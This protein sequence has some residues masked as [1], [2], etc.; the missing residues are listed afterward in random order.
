MELS[1]GKRGTGQGRVVAIAP[2]GGDVSAPLTA[3]NNQFYTANAAYGQGAKLGAGYAVYNGT[4]HS[5]IVTGLQPNTYYYVTNAEYNTD[6]VSI[7][8]NIRG[9]S[10]S[11]ATRAAPTAPLP[12]EL[13]TFT[14]TTD[15]NSYATLQWNTATER[16]TDYFAIERSTDSIAFTETGRM[17]AAGSSTR[18]L[19]Y[20]WP[21]PKRLTASTYYRLRQVDRNGAVHYSSVVALAPAP[22][23][24][25]QVEVYP[26]PSVGRPVKLLLQGYAGESLSMHLF[27]ALGRPVLVQTITPT[28]VHYLSPL[29]LPKN[30]PAGTYFLSLASSG[31]ITQKRI[32][33]SD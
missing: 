20:Q 9:S 8:Y 17:A 23:V 11:T 7:T 14:G 26:N 25:R 32:V 33:I 3:V 12:V 13:T 22:R 6:S 10:F 19:A 31:N 24:A 30:L 16:N 2:T 27:D 28:E 18:A 15:A 1:F 5:I 29:S 21:D 4:G